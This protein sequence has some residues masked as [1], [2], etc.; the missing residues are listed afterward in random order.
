MAAPAIAAPPAATPD[1]AVAAGRRIYLDG[2]LPSGKPVRGTMQG[3]VT[4]TGL[5][6]SCGS[7]HRRSGFGASEAGAVAPPVIGEFLYRPIA[8]GAEQTGLRRSHG[9]GTRPAY[10][11]ETLARAIRQGVDPTGRA[12]DPLMPR[13]ELSDADAAALVAYLKTLGSGPSPGVNEDTIHLATVVT[14]GVSEARR[15]ALLDVL[16]AFLAD[17]NVGSRLED[18]RKVR[19]GWEMKRKYGAWRRL[20]LHVWELDG[21]SASWRGQLE[22]SCRAQPVFALLSGI[23]SGDWRPVHEFCEANEVPCLFPITDQP[24]VAAADYYSFYFS[25]GLGLEA[26]ALATHLRDAQLDGPVLQ[27]FRAGSPGVA[28]AAA[29]RQAVAGA[30]VVVDRELAGVGPPQ[31]AFWR[32]LLEGS[33]PAALVLWLGE[34]DLGGLAAAPTGK[35]AVYLSG[36]LLSD[37]TAGALPPLPAGARLTWP[38]ALPPAAGTSP[39]R[40]RVWLKSR[41]LGQVDERVQTGAFFAA[42]LFNDGLKELHG[43]FVRDYLIERIEHMVDSSVTTSVYPRVSLSPGVRFA[44]KGCSIVRL[45][46]G[47]PPAPEPVSD[48]IVP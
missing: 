4:F 25:R 26:E 12:F 22:Q 40:A 31:A 38:F 36:S 32:S 24:V 27:V 2:V 8:V 7:C 47:D 17:R 15:A 14:P 44:S 34:A 46:P 37:G 3:D 28:A 16:Q 33:P 45:G 10:T 21:P 39:S 35:T 30:A 18:E 41:G 43:Y 20:A 42:S 1:P 5:Q 23:G 19:S 48:W 13:F 29:F 11:D 9:P 6:A